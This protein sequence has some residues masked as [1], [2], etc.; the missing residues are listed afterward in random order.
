[1][2][3][4]IA[5]IDSTGIANT[6]DIKAVFFDID[7][8]LTSFTTHEVPAS[9][10]RALHELKKRGILVFLCTG[11]AIAHLDV[12]MSMLPVDFDGI[13]AMNGQY[14]VNDDGVIDAY[15]LDNNDVAIIVAWL[16]QHPD[17]TASFSEADYVYVNQFSNMLQ[18]SR[19]RLGKTAPQRLVDDPHTRIHTHSTF[20][21]SP[22]IT[23]E[24]E[25]E[26]VG[27]CHNTV[28]VRWHPDFTDLI[29]SDGGK[30]RGMQCFLRHHGIAREQA[31]AFGDG[32]NDIAMLHYAGI[33]VAMG[34]A[35]DNVKAAADIVTDD[36]DHDGVL[37]ALQRCGVL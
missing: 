9:T 30:P 10:I 11:R 36:V 29:P 37:N 23:T 32:G 34:N 16:D 12:V 20:Q 31:M 5:H 18:R 15:P 13:V 8:T 25:T 17:V 3:G 14:C 21:I 1:M 28:G 7:G 2:T 27:L 26:L 6:A 19:E 22:F 4:N 35:A 24:Q 33:G